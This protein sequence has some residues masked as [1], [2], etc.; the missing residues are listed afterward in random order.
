MKSRIYD[1]LHM[2]TLGVARHVNGQLF[3][4]LLEVTNYHDCG[5]ADLFRFGAEMVGDLGYHGLGE[6]VQR[7]CGKS[8]E[9][10][11]Q[12]RVAHNCALF[13]RLRDD[14]NSEWLLKHTHRMRPS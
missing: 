4:T 6:Q 7:Q 13:K 1:I 12:G 8:K 14:E 5:A 9:D 11:W 10:L 2:Q 3:R